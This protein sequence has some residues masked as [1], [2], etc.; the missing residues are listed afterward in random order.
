MDESYHHDVIK[1]LRKNAESIAKASRVRDD[2]GLT[3]LSMTATSLET[4]DAES[5]KIV[6]SPEFQTTDGSW[7]PL[8]QVEVSF[9]KPKEPDSKKSI[10]LGTIKGYGV[11]RTEMDSAR[12]AEFRRI[13][14]EE[15]PEDAMAAVMSQFT[16]MGLSD[17]Q[18]RD[19]LQTYLSS[20]QE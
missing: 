6:L 2:D 18:I 3:D 11:G 1:T 9:Q 17:D 20:R 14:E 10:T 4:D 19:Q 13:P 16:Q 7:Q 15:E 8:R 12:E 5:F